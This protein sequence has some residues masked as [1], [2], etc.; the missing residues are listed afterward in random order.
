M[1]IR[2]RVLVGVL[3][4]SMVVTGTGRVMTDAVPGMLDEVTSTL[5]EVTDK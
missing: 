3:L 2:D 1:C 4:L 5:V